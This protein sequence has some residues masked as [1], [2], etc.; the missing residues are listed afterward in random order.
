MGPFIEPY[1]K[2]SIGGNLIIFNKNHNITEEGNH[3]QLQ[4]NQKLQ[5]LTA[6]HRRSLQLLCTVGGNQARL[7]T[8]SEFKILEPS[9]KGG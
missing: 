5:V 3:K 9:P 4:V 2:Y 8:R 6:K 1:Y 7:D